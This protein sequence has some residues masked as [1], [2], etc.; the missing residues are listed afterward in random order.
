MLRSVVKMSY[1]SIKNDLENRII[2][3]LKVNPQMS[4][5]DAVECVLQSMGIITHFNQQKKNNMSFEQ[6]R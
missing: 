4:Y 2:S 5:M 1:S 3:T 6:V